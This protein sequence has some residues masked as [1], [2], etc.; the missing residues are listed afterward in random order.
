MKMWIVV[1][2]ADDGGDKSFRNFRNHIQEYKASQPRAQ[3]LI[4]L[5]LFND[6]LSEQLIGVLFWY[7][8]Y[9]AYSNTY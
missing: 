1:L 8:K 9:R 2:W 4:F 5:L 7:T 6:D 3:S